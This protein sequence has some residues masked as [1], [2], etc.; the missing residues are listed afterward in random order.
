MKVGVAGNLQYPGLADVL[1]RVA[2]SSRELGL[3]FVV[4]ASIQAM[5]P[6]AVGLPRSRRTTGVDPHPRR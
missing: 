6:S 5:W 1:G 4:E 3:E 2:A